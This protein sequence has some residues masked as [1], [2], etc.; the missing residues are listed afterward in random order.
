MAGNALANYQVCETLS[1]HFNDPVMAY[2]YQDMKELSRVDNKRAFTLN[3][4][5]KIEEEYMSAFSI[6]NKLNKPSLF[7]LC[8]SRFDT[9]SRQHYKTRLNRTDN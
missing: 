3:D 6:L 1:T 9:V 8:L 5:D 2:Y 7:Q 4:I